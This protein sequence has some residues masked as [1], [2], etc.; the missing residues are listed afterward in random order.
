MKRK[1]FTVIGFIGH[2]FL[3]EKPSTKNRDKEQGS[4]DEK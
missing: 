4:K 3:V 2:I 1:L